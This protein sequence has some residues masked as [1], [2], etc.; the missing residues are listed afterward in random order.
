MFFKFC[1]KHN[2]KFLPASDNTL[3]LFITHLSNRN[4]AISTIKVYISSIVTLHNLNGLVPPNPKNAQIRLAL[5]AIANK[6]PEPE[7]KSPITFKLLQ[8]IWQVI[9]QLP[10][11]RCIQA[12]ITLGFFGGLRGA[13][14]LKTRF[15]PGPKFQQ[16]SFIQ[17][18]KE[19]M[20]YQ[21]KKSKTKPKGFMVPLACSRHIICP[22]CSMSNYL[23]KRQKTQQLTP[24]SPLL[25]Y[26][27]Y[28]LTKAK[29]NAILKD[30][31]KALGLTPANYST[32]SLRA[33][34]ATTAAAS[35]FKEWE[36]KLLGGWATNTC[37]TY[38]RPTAQH[39]RNFATR[40]AR[41]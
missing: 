31:V 12:A 15:S 30:L 37:N 16:I 24:D 36:L 6:S 5:R 27:G 41:K 18:K 28:E 33:G 2:L 22:V 3:L 11:Y 19:L 39:R 32:H 26:L 9:T 14:Y 40:L 1:K 8:C 20:N 7:Q 23:A 38:I 35:N 29:F 21:V 10:D 34:V 25:S 17:G 13:E 4:L